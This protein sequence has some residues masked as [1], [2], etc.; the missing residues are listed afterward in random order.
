MRS[1]CKQLYG[2]PALPRALPFILYIALL[3]LADVLGQSA[4]AAYDVRL[5]YPCK[6]ACVALLLV[7]FWQRYG[8]LTRFSLQLPQILWSLI[9]GVAVFLI[10]INLDQAWTVSYTH[11]R[12]HE[13][14]SYLVCRLLLEKKKKDQHCQQ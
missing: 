6:V 12:A 13:T 2:H 8:E 9:T 1:L 11:L 10:W 4:S 3:A 7:F 14:D 5:I